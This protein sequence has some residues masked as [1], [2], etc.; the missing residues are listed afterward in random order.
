MGRGVIAQDLGFFLI[1]IY[2]IEDGGTLFC[3][4]DVM[5]GLYHHMEVI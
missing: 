3:N 5:E 1:F 4:D 2:E